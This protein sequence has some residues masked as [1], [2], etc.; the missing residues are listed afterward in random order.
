MKSICKVFLS[1]V[2]VVFM[3][4]VGTAVA[5]TPKAVKI[6]KE[7]EQLQL[8]ADKAALHRQIKR[9]EADEARW[10]ADQAEGK[11]SAMS[12]DAYEVYMGKKAVLGEAKDIVNDKAFSLQMNVDKSAL[13]RQIMQLEAAEARL[14]ADKAEGKMSAESKDADRVYNDK[15]DIKGLKKDIAA[16]KANLKADQ[17]K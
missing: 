13:Q 1:A 4:T 8:K 15:Q 11:M 17:K 16:D 10:K 2:A 6:K 9:V 7:Q 3:F 14:K 12:R 5:Q